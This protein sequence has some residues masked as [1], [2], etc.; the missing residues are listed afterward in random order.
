MVRYRIWIFLI[1]AITLG[2]IM[3]IYDVDKNNDSRSTPLPN[4]SDAHLQRISDGTVGITNKLDGSSGAYTSTKNAAIKVNDGTYNRVLVGLL[5]DGTYGLKVSQLNYDVTTATDD[6]LIFNSNQN[7]FKIV[8]ILTGTIPATSVSIGAGA[9]GSDFKF[10]TIP[11]GLSYIPAIL[12]FMY[13]G[14][15]MTPLPYTNNGTTTQGLVTLNYSA[16][17]DATNVYVNAK[18]TIYSTLASNTSSATAGVKIYVLQ[19]TAN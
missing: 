17:A 16:T 12:A 10:I 1:L 3:A 14:F 2:G 13:D 4:A 18:T 11:H 8:K 6:N 7:S 9:S 19:E 15:N 5:P